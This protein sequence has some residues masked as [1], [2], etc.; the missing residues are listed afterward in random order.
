MTH[1]GEALEELAELKEL[2]K[3][4]E[5]KRAKA[6]K[7]QEHQRAKIQKQETHEPPPKTKEKNNIGIG[8]YALALLFAGTMGVIN[9]QGKQPSDTVDEPNKPTTET[10]TETPS[11]TPEKKLYSSADIEPIDVDIIIDEERPYPAMALAYNEANNQGYVAANSNLQKAQELALKKCNS[12]TSAEVTLCELDTETQQEAGERG[13]IATFYDTPDHSNDPT[14]DR[15]VVSETEEGGLDVIKEYY[16]FC[17]SKTIKHSENVRPEECLL[18]EAT[19][20]FQ[21]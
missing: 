10:V 2:Q 16:G 6:Q 4:E 19:C 3:A 1:F 12:D 9:N 5:K 18:L 11:I 15:W 21:P 20:N 13:C 8:T 14:P 17:A 7:R